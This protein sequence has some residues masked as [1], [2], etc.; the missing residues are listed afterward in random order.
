MN[1]SYLMWWLRPISTELALLSLFLHSSL[2][3]WPSIA[4]AMTVL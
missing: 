2:Y 4:P 3:I 1:Q